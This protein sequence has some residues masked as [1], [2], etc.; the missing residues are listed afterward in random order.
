MVNWFIEKEN[1]IPLYLQLKDLIKYY[2]STGAIKDHQQL[3]G[4]NELAR[5]L[6]INFDTVRKAYKELEKEGLVSMKRG[7]GT[8][9]NLRDAALTDISPESHPELDPLES[10]RSIIR[11]LLRHGMTLTAIEK[12]LQ[13]ALTEVSR[14]V[15]RQY[16]IFTECNPLQV[17]EISALLQE[18]L[19]IKVR[20]VILSD[21]EETLTSL[22]ES[23]GELLAIVTTGFHVNEVQGLLGERPID[24]HMLVT[25]MS[26]DT[27]RKL[28]EYR[29]KSVFGFICRDQ[30][31][32][33][34]YSDLLRS[35]LGLSR[36][37]ELNSTI[38]SDDAAVASIL[39]KADV[40]LAT[41]P[42]FE[43][44]RRR[45][46][47]GLAVFNVFE[48]VDPMSLMML[49]DNLFRNSSG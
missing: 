2:I 3:P 47:N 28:D 17:K 1:K 14:D 29:G 38:L 10:A 36:D 4:V 20:P 39:E 48:R 23:D 49:K 9:V 7:T 27:R 46:P 40:L 35:E 25:N 42:V 44:V 22:P 8:F 16:V 41:P 21:L 31:S 33:P 18:S 24:V 6:N 12:L 34:F 11:R 13:Q 15:G 19:N 37:V 30:K 32:V 43:E 45:A 5:D 26:P